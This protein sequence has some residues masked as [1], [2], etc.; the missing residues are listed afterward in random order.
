M[1]V[2]KNRMNNKKNLEIYREGD[3]GNKNVQ[4]IYCCLADRPM[5]MH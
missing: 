1:T 4:V 3:T 5:C 2:C